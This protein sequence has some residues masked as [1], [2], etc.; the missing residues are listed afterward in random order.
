MNKQTYYKVVDSSLRSCVMSKKILDPL[1]VP[2]N[3]CVQYKIGEFVS[4]NNNTPL[5]VFNNMSS[6][7]SF[8]YQEKNAGPIRIFECEIK[9]KRKPFFINPHALDLYYKRLYEMF[10]KKK[11]FSHLVQ[12]DYPKDTIFCSQVKLVKELQF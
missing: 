9:N 1:C 6:A 12:S 8:A 2:Y 11:K 7:I 10:K 4:S 5:F 3:L